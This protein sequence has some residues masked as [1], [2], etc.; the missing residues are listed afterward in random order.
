MTA[1]DLFADP[2]EA[3]PDGNPVLCIQREQ[4]DKAER[5]AAIHRTL[6][7]IHPNGHVLEL[8]I[9]KQSGYRKQILNGYFRDKAKAAKAALE[10][11]ADALAIYTTFNPI[12]EALYALAPDCIRENIKATS[13]KDVTRR[14]WLP[15]DIDPIRA[16]SVSSTDDELKAA[17]V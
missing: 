15:I 14:H 1:D 8:R 5:S 12:D 13:D 7:T 3:V 10:H 4:A 17:T 16:A 9:I 2:I 6:T 11:D